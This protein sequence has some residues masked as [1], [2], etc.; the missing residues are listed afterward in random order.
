MKLFFQK[1]CTDQ[2]ASSLKTKQ[3][4]FK[5]ISGKKNCCKIQY[6]GYNWAFWGFTVEGSRS[7]EIEREW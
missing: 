7:S 4:S 6:H 1:K 5:F 2:K 3:I